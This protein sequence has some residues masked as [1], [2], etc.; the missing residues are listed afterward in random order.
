M[1]ARFLFITALLCA[2][3]QPQKAPPAAGPSD[4]WVSSGGELFLDK[5]NPWWLANTTRVGYCIRTDPA[6]FALSEAQARTAVTE[7]IQYW[8]T[9]FA[10]AESQFF[11]KPQPQLISYGVRT[12]TT[13]T[14]RPLGIASQTFEEVPC[15]SADL[16]FLFG[17]GSLSPT[18]AGYL[19][20]AGRYI[21]AAVRTAYD[22]VQMRGQG[23]VY[24]TG[25]MESVRAPWRL[26]AV[27][28]HELGHVFGIRHL[29]PRSSIMAERFPE[30]SVYGVRDVDA[31]ALSVEAVSLPRFFRLPDW[32][33]ACGSLAQDALKYFAGKAEPKDCLEFRFE[34]A[35][36]RLALS[37][38]TESGPAV[39]KGNIVDLD[40]RPVFDPAVAIELPEGQ[41]VFTVPAPLVTIFF[42][43]AVLK[44]ASGPARYVPLDGSPAKPVHLQFQGPTDWWLQITAPEGDRLKRILDVGFSL[45]F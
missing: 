1:I 27:V 28:A 14:G 29:G 12:G 36:K 11:G 45:V 10:G 32:Q 15:A 2:G 37:V 34:N 24:V 33:L 43:P 26:L 25:G 30:T 16:Q 23:Y 39:E 31:A 40:I 9:E 7:A 22:P 18:Q 21:A 17:P 13:V 4:G 38:R 6:T 35:P 20:S 19:G 42:G 8:K 44:G 3:C 41:T 5:Q